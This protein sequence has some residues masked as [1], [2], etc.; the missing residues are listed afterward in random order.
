VKDL[1]KLLE[2]TGVKPAKN[3]L[4]DLFEAFGRIFAP[5][6]QNNNINPQGWRKD[7]IDEE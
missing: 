7:Q 1:N 6:E 3:E 2:G 5:Y 4:D